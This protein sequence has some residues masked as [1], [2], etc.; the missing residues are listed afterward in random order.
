MSVSLYSN[1]FPMATDLITE[2][3][4]FQQD[5]SSRSQDFLGHVNGAHFFFATSLFFIALLICDCDSDGLISSNS[6]SVSRSSSNL[7]MKACRDALY[8][9]GLYAQFLLIHEPNK[10]ERLFPVIEQFTQ[11]L[12]AHVIVMLPLLESLEDLFDLPLLLQQFLDGTIRCQ[13]FNFFLLFHELGNG[14]T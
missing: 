6:D 7:S 3:H 2:F 11:R 14:S 9:F 4:V 12:R 5:I 10:K 13:L 1:I 8:S